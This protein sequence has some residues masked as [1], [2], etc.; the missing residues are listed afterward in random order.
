MQFLGQ[1]PLCGELVGYE[2]VQGRVQ[3]PDGYREPL[4]GFKNTFKITALHGQQFPQGLF[5]PLNGIGQDHF[6]HS[7]DP[8]HLKE[9]VLGPGQANSP[10]PKPPCTQGVLRIG[11]GGPDLHPGVFIGEGHQ[12]AKFPTEFGFLGRDLALQDIPGGAID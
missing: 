9:H 3:E 2:F 10:G 6:P 4:H 7:L 1:L 11:G 5:A 12:L 8:V